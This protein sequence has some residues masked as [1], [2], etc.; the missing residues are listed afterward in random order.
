MND[1]EIEAKLD[2]VLASSLWDRRIRRRTQN[3]QTA[4]WAEQGHY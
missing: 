1:S 4:A 2:V 3:V